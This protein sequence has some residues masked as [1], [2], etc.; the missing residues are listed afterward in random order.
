MVK[1]HYD[2]MKSE[3]LLCALQCQHGILDTAYSWSTIGQRIRYEIDACMA[4][5]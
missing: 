3:N 4:I 1:I 2:I 5:A